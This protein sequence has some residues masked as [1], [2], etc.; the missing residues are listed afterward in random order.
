[1][2]NS[3]FVYSDLWEAVKPS[4]KEFRKRTKDMQKEGLKWI[5]GASL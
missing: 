5:M 3:R 1:M 2:I 4:A